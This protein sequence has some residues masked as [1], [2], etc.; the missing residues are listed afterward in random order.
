MLTIYGM[1]AHGPV[2]FRSATAV[3]HSNL[4]LLQ[5]LY[6]RGIGSVQELNTELVV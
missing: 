6:P 2:G 5:F 1:L 4:K 3:A